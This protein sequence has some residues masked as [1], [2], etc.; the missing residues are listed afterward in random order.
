MTFP[1]T[2]CT[3]R[4]LA[5][6]SMSKGFQS[7]SLGLFALHLPITLHRGCRYYMATPSEMKTQ[8]KESGF[9]LRTPDSHTEQCTTLNSR[10]GPS[11]AAYSKETGI[12]HESV[13][14]ELQ[15]FSVA[16]GALLPGVMHDVLEGILQYEAKLLLRHLIYDEGCFTLDQLNSRIGRMELGFM[17]SSNRPSQISATTLQSQDSNLLTQNGWSMWP[18]WLRCY[19]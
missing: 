16:S 4:K 15:Y 3:Y 13:L 18:H 5:T 7:T 8:F 6:H 1:F 19:L 14:D 2:L 12:N 17:E 11:R 9:E 10:M